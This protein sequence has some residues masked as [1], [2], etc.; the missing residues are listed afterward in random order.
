M[1]LGVFVER[2]LGGMNDDDHSAIPCP[3]WRWVTCDHFLEK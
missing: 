2:L 1:N 3:D